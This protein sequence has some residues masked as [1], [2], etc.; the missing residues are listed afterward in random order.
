VEQVDKAR[1][2]VLN[3]LEFSRNKEFFKE[4]LNLNKIIESTLGLL[5]GQVP[6]GVKVRAEIPPNLTIFAD[7]QRIQQAFMNLIGNA[8]QACRAEGEVRIRAEGSYDEMVTMIIRDTGTGIREED[9]PKIFDPFFT[10]KDVGQGTGLGLFITHD[11]I[12]RHNGSIKVTS[13][14]DSGTSFTIKLPAKEPSE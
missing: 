12:V 2:I 9:L 11:I 3:L 5:H 10:T 4:S 13:A 6:P 8:I 14:P 7:K 1:G